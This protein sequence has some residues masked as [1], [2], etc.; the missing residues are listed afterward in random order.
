MIFE[1]NISGPDTYLGIEQ[2]LARVVR[3]YWGGEQVGRY[4]DWAAPTAL[5]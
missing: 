3:T 4:T 2:R 1:Q 5:M